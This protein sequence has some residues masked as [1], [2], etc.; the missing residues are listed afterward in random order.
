MI[1]FI[2]RK[3]GLEDTYCSIILHFMWSFM[4]LT[5]DEIAAKI[6]RD[7][8][9]FKLL[10]KDKVYELLEGAYAYDYHHLF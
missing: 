3:M 9:G 1:A 2:I 7:Y 6:C 8:R 5:E 10:A 4:P